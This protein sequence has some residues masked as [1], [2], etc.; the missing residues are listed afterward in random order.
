MIDHTDVANGLMATFAALA[1][2]LM[3][4]F[5]GRGDRGPGGGD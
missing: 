1:L 5:T 3:V 4:I 2:L